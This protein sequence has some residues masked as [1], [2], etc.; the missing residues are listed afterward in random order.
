MAA[1]SAWKFSPAAV[2]MIAAEQGYQEVA[3]A[4]QE[5]KSKLTFTHPNKSGCG[6]SESEVK[7]Y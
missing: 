5:R 7:I 4:E 2:R 6:G 1:A 3:L